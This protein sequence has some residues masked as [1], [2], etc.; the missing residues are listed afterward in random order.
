MTSA[1]KDEQAPELRGFRDVQ[2][3]AS[4]S[5]AHV[6]VQPITPTGDTFPS[7]KLYAQLSLW[8]TQLVRRSLPGKHWVPHWIPRTR[9]YHRFSPG[10][11]RG[12]ARLKPPL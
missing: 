12:I 6:P 4:F 5:Y 1:V 3:L 8:A 7:E 11:L 9:P 10:A 2:R